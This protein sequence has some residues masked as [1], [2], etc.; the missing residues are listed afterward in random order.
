MKKDGKKKASAPNFDDDLADCIGQARREKY[1]LALGLPLTGVEL[2][3]DVPETTHSPQP[4]P[5]QQA[6]SVQEAAGILKV[7]LVTVYR[8][9]QRGKLRCLQSV[10][11]KRIPRTELERFIK[12]DLG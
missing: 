9:I 8:L 4:A 2:V 1:R 6:Y 7:S 10:R 3:A 12:D 5:A 11:H